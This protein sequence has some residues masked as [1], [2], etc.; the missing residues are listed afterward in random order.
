MFLASQRISKNFVGALILALCWS[1]SAVAERLHPNL[2]VTQSDIEAIKSGISAVPLA[3]KALVDLRLKVDADL[4]KTMDVPVPKDA[5]G[6]YTHEQHKLNYQSMYN[7]G[8]LFQLTGED[9]YLQYVREML[10]QYVQLYPTLGIHPKRKEQTPGKLFWQSLNESVWLVHTIQAYDFVANSLSDIDREVI[11]TKLLRPVANYLSVGQPKTFNKIH[12][13]GTWAVAAVGMTGY[14]LDD[15]LL[16]KQALYDLEQSGK[17]G[18]LRQIEQLFSP[19]GYYAEGPYYQRYALMP[20]VLFA[21]AID[22]NQPELKIFSYRDKALLKAIETTIQLSYNK[23]FFGINDAIKDKGIETIEL[24]H[25]VAIAYQF[26]QDPTLLSIAKRQNQT[27][28]TGYG[29]S[30]A[31]AINQGLTQPFNY[32][33]MLLRDGVDGDQG[34]LAIFRSGNDLAHQALVMKNTS[35]G[36]GHGHYDKLH[37]LY[38]DNGNEIVSDY[39]AARFLNIEAKYGG[40]YL[41]ENNAFAKQT[42]AHNTLVVDEKS[43]FYGNFEVAQASAPRVHF[44]D[45]TET[46]KITSASIDNAY[47]GVVMKR[48]MAMINVDGLD[49][50]L[51]VDIFDVASDKIHQYDL[52]I[53]YQG[54]LISHTNSLKTKASVLKPLGVDNGYQFLWNR[55]QAKIDTPLAQLTWLKDGRFYTYSMTGGVRKKMIFAQI[56]ANDPNFNLRNESAL[57]QRVSGAKNQTFVSVLEAHGEYNG[58]AEYTRN[59]ISSISSLNKSVSASSTIIDIALNNGKKIIL[60]LAQESDPEKVH[61]VRHNDGQLKWNGPYALI[62]AE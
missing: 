26:T 37:W 34:A 56:G 22:V 45:A 49:Y 1:C 39:G 16:V 55:G 8:L 9:K 51:I 21:K 20:F 60:A 44:Y 43:H 11:E 31:S 2:T 41:P 50:P 54:Q 27:L 25:G 58:T 15:E 13:H 6:G 62:K 33:S 47:D 19:D 7:A 18:F 28:L 42:V 29:F 3:Q 53:Y 32:K 30:V 24:V 52:P 61:T 46:I 48:T 10:L 35:Q 59:A 5:G 4:S 36:L 17:G 38:F 14:V 12:N 23:L 57:I 40:H